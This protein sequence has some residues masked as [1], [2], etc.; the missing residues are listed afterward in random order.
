LSNNQAQVGEKAELASFLATIG[1]TATIYLSGLLPESIEVIRYQYPFALLSLVFI[2][3]FAV[4]RLF[5]CIFLYT[6][7]FRALQWT[8]LLCTVGIVVIGVSYFRNLQISGRPI[9]TIDKSKI[10][11]K[12]TGDGNASLT[13]SQYLRPLCDLTQFPEMDFYS[14]GPLE[15]DDFTITIAEIEDKDRMANIPCEIKEFRMGKFMNVVTEGHKLYKNKK[16]LRTTVMDAPGAFTDTIGDEFRVTLPYPIEALDVTIVFD[17]CELDINRVTFQQVARSGN[18]LSVPESL[19]LTL[20][21]PHHISYFR[22]YPSKGDQYVVSW[23]YR[24]PP[25]APSQNQP[26]TNQ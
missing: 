1:L 5:M 24:V 22:Q 15:K 10:D 2:A 19:S 11:V 17:G 26:S 20:K 4:T 21:D 7:P 13:R 18:L 16:Y 3:S 12:I 14:S 9:L 6:K 25:R 8:I 23:Y